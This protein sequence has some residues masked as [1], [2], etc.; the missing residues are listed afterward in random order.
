[1]SEDITS[2]VS[3]FILK[4]HKNLFKNRIQKYTNDYQQNWFSRGSFDPSTTKE[5]LASY[6]YCN[7]CFKQGFSFCNDVLVTSWRKSDHYC[8]N[9]LTSWLQYKKLARKS[10]C[11]WC[12]GASLQV[13]WFYLG[14][15]NDDKLHPSMSSSER[16]YT[17]RQEYTLVLQ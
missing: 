1:M 7:F 9:A 11:W 15:S 17:K 16:L 5:G 14:V 2:A 10:T 12:N 13:Y 3:R 4:N 6:I 8:N